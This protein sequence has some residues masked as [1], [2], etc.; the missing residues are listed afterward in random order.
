MRREAVVRVLSAEEWLTGKQW[1]ERAGL[2]EY[3]TLCVLSGL[4]IQGQVRLQRSFPHEGGAIRVWSLN[5]P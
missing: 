3:I 4:Y 2:S 1:A 5:P